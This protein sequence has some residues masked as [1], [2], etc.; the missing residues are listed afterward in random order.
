LRTS[1]FD[2]VLGEILSRRLRT[3]TI[4]I[5]VMLSA[6]IIR[7]WF[8]QIINGPLYRTQSENNRIHLQ[9]IHPF[10]GLIMDRNGDLLVDN[11]P[12]YDLYFIPEDVQDKK[13]LFDSIQR[14]IPLDHKMANQKLSRISSSNLY[15]PLVIKKNITREELAIIETNLFNLP[16]ARTQFRPQRNYIYGDFASHIIGHLGEINERQL[17]SGK[18]PK[19][20]AGDFIG[21]YGVEGKWQNELNGKRGGEQVEVDVYGRKLRT[22]TRK[23]PV[24]GFNI[25]LAID[26]E[27]QL[28]AEASLKGKE[29][30]IVALDPNT[31]EVLVMASRPAFNPNKFVGGINIADWNKLRNSKKHPQQNRAINGQYAPGSVFKIVVAL[32]GLEEGIIDPEEEILCTGKYKLGNHTYQCWKKGGH[33]KVN[34]HKAIRESCDVYFYK[35]GLKLGIDTIAQYARMFGLGKKTNVDLVSEEEGLIPDSEWK[36]KNKGEVWQQG[37]TISCA[38]GQSYVTVTPIQMASMISAVFNGGMIYQPKVVK[39]VG[40]DTSEV[41]EF[42]PNLQR[43]LDFSDNNM[44]LVKEALIAVVNEPHGTGF[45]HA[46]IKGINVAGKTGTAQVINLE[47]AKKINPDG[48]VPDEFLDH[49]WFVAI[50]PAENPK[51]AVAVIVEHGEHGGSTSGP[52]AKK[53]IEHYLKE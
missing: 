39:R 38:I 4:L 48:D 41:F 1:G 51:I 37:E 5:I 40:Y 14:L 3:L 49:A 43:T 16:G 33:K 15:N 24:P 50:A 13:Q 46:R 25:H 52:I 53:L 35:V 21:Q 17:N 2:P 32:A 31:G 20:S 18:Y 42:A 34:L 45:N 23:P 19:N 47:A 6:L 22:M 11:R 27:L 30:A 26:K 10:R 12:S 7:L 44:K 9:K 8:L 29:G 36:L 28:L